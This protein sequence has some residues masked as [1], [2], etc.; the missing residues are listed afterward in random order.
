[1]AGA[2][3]QVASAMKGKVKIAK[4]DATVETGVPPRFGV[5]GFP[6]IKLF[7][8]GKKSDSSVVDYNGGRDAQSLQAFAEKY[9]AMTVEAEQLLSQEMFDEKCSKD[10]GTLCLI[11]FLPHIMESSAK[12]R[13]QY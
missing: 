13:K 7:P 10:S 5:Q 4:M 3:D 8:S 2:W 12:D 9:Y 11:A 6:T 1:M